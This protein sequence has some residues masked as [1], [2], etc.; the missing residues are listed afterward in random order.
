[1]SKSNLRE[2]VFNTKY[3]KY[4]PEKDRKETFD[5]A[6]D[7]LIN[8]HREFF[9]ELDIED[10]LYK[11]SFAM[12]NK[13]ILGSQRAMQYGGD[14]ILKKHARLFNCSASHCDR[15]KVFQD[16]FW[17]LLCGCGVGLSVQAQHIAKLPNIKKPKG[18]VENWII[19]D[20][21]EG[22]ADAVGGLLSTY[23]I[24][25]KPFNINST[26]NFD[27]S[28]IRP[29]GAHLSSG[30]GCAPGPEP[31]KKS[32]ETIRKLLNDITSGGE[33]K[34][35]SIEAYDIMMHLSDAV[36]SGGVRRS[37][38]L[39]MFSKNDDE[40]LK[41]KTGNWF[42]ENPQRGRSNNSVHLLRNETTKQEFA[43]I[44]KSIKEFGEPGFIWT[45][46]L[47]NMYNPCVE[48]GLYPKL[49]GK[50]GFTFCNLSE[51]NMSKVTSEEDLLRAAEAAAIIGTLQAAY[52]DFAYLGTTSE[53]L[54][55]K[56]ALLGV[57]MTG[58]MDTPDIAFSPELQRKAAK[59]VLRVNEQVAD[60]IGIN[61]SARTTCVK[62]SGSAACLLSTSSGIHPH[63]SKRYFRRAQANTSEEIVDIIKNSN[64]YCVEES[65]W[66][67]SKTD[68]VITFCIEA[69]EKAM[70]K[71]DV[72]AVKL[73]ELVKLTCN[74][75]IESGRRHEVCVNDSVRHNVSNTISVKDNEWPE[76]E[77]FIYKNRDTLAGV[78]LLADGG[79]IDYPQAPFCEVL[80]A[81][82]IVEKYGVG[83][84]MS[85]GL[86]VN[87]LRVFNTLWE[88]CDYALGRGSLT[89]IL[90]NERHPEVTKA[91]KKLIED[92]KEWILK[93]KK[94][95]N[96]YFGGDVLKMTR[97]LKRV[98]NCKLWEDIKRNQSPINFKKLKAS[99]KIQ[100]EVTCSG[101]SCELI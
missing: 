89:D 69:N 71:K 9:K 61:K 79:D 13:L 50:S 77:E 27:Y 81:N 86:I 56:E 99:A 68:A 19:E 34:L 52:T 76:V 42:V 82:E 47:E 65:V 96:N 67:A 35:K 11:C 20:S 87:G 18:D 16:A 62:P 36:L 80:K 58:M 97:C 55:R 94:F 15:P 60:R 72:P 49:D 46:N 12:K 88:A 24:S 2:Y 4:L 63:H 83:S 75:W 95:A 29:K 25:D 74:N 5:E 44:V 85:S 28:R 73:L 98:H 51:I 14:P 64:P 21:I 17:L 23:F 30:A 45:D 59:H 33:H 54:A 31:L 1:M 39:I 92:R 3:S 37:A 78:S 101:G 84:I 40:M 53:E 6:V 66:S 93:A 41:A 100:G 38:M 48:A 8:M 70:T 22:W 7:R 90:S 43:K 32:I 57:S 26:L 10:L 91:L